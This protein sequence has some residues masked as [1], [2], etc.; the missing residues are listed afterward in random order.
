MVEG[1]NMAQIPMT[2]QEVK[3][4]LD[5]LS[6]QIDKYAELLVKK[7][8]AISEGSQLVI[9]ASIEIADFVRRVQRAAYA[10][11]AEFVTV[12]WGDQ[13]SSRI[14]YENVDLARLSKTP[15]WKIEQLNSLAEQGAA[16]LFLSSDDPNG[17]KGIDPEKPAAVSRA[18]N[19]EC[20]VFRNGMD[21]GKNVWCIAG[22][23]AAEWAKVIFPELSE[24]EAIYRL[25]I[26]ILDVAHA[27]G[28][29]PQSAWETHNATFEKTKRFMNSHQFEEL[30]YESS[31]GTN[32]TICMNPGHLW[33]GGAG[34]TQDGTLF[35]PNIP[36]EEVFTTPNYRKVNGTVHSAL[37]LIHAG[38]IVK[39]FWFTFK[40]GEVVDYGAEQGKDVL[41]SIVSQK[42]GKY[43]G[44][45]ALISKNTPI[46]QSGI[47]FYDTLY[48]ENASCHLA[49]GM[50]FPECL[51][52]GLEMSPDE[53]LAHGVNQS[54][55]HVDFMIG[56]DDLNIW[57]I[58]A[59]GKETPIFVNGQWAWE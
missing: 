33:E 30:H 20:D 15:S 59:D 39:N 43:L 52:G 29:D 38:Q 8:C 17:L 50:G 41:T 1:N 27:S 48:D 24:A 26:A 35:F 7:G 44:E 21:F 47:L 57:G 54:T 31:N 25:W 40:D 19:L 14:M 51:K 32:L 11:G 53:L 2:D 56:A 3:I 37:P 58:S 45:C 55:T 10:A 12:I 6:D 9:N 28:E 49:L 18:R 4:A 42:G 22:V 13:E 23:P 46:R 34:K 16:F 36:T 5:A